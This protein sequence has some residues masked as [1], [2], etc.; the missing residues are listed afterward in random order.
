MDAF[1]TK[2]RQLRLR[3]SGAPPKLPEIPGLLQAFRTEN[4][5]RVVCVH[6]NETTEKA[7]RALGPVEMETLPISLEDA[8]ISYLCERGEKTFILSETE[9][10]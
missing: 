1:R 4:E 8:F 3:F 6:Y 7:L 9:A 2:I 5:L 10:P